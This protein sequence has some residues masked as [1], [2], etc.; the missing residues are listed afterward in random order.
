[1]SVGGSS[2]LTWKQTNL[3]K[4]TFIRKTGNHCIRT[5]RP[6]FHTTFNHLSADDPIA[7]CRSLIS[8]SLSE[9]AN[10]AM[11]E[12]EENCLP[13]RLGKKSKSQDLKS[14]KW[15]KRKDWIT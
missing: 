2:C 9:E 15:E 1:M 6:S 14:L 4:H 3:V 12:I 13:D 8:L 7:M 5:E 10:D 11:Q